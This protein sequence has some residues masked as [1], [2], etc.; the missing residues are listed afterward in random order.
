MSGYLQVPLSESAQEKTAFITPD[1]TGQFTRLP[2]GLAGTPGE[3][4]RLMRKVLGSF[5]DRIVNNYLDDWV[6]DAEDRPD[7]LMKLRI[8]LDELRAANLTLKL[9]KCLFGVKS[10]EFLGF[11]IGGG[12]ICPGPIKSQA[13]EKWSTVCADSLASSDFSDILYKTMLSWQNLY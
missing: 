5:K 11:V 12:Q 10:I 2:F 8:V 1:D 6:V 7:M 4:T 13:I 9:S 3:L